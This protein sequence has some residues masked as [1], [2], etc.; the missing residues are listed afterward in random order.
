MKSFGAFLASALAAVLLISC[1]GLSVPGVSLNLPTPSLSSA[2]G[3]AAGAMDFKNDE[4]LSLYKDTDVMNGIY[5]VARVLTP[6]S[7]ATK[8]QAEVIFVEDGKKDWSAR[9]LPSKK[10]DKNDAK[11]GNL[12]LYPRGWQGHDKMDSEQYR[13]SSWAIGHV[14]NNDELFK[15]YLEVDGEKFAVSLLRV[16]TVPVE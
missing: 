12:I 10:A 3:S 11:I 9:V 14:T 1:A 15:N 4:I 2:V 5:Y 6:A 8:N 16:P 13:K 7:P